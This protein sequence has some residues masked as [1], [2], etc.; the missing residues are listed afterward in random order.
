MKKILI[1]TDCDFDD[2]TAISL[3]LCQHVQKHVMIIGI[4]CDDGFLQFPDNISWIS[5][6]LSLNGINDIPIIKGFPSTS[7][8]LSERKF[9]S[10]W[11]LDYKKML[12]ENYNVDFSQIPP[13]EDLEPFIEKVK[14]E[15]FVVN[16]LSPLRSYGI[17]LRRYCHFRN[18]R[19]NFTGGG[20]ITDQ[21]P[22]VNSTW[23][24]FLDPDG[25]RDYLMFSNCASIVL[26]STFE[27]LEFNQE[28][29]KLYKEMGKKY[30]LN[31]YVS[32]DLKNIFRKTMTFL[33]NYLDYEVR[34]SGLVLWDVVTTMLLL[35]YPMDQRSRSFSIL[36]SWT[37]GTQIESQKCCGKEQVA[38]KTNSF[39]FL[40]S[41]KFNTQFV[42]RFFE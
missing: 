8:L 29:L 27:N 11:V 23:N 7:Y 16:L 40:D 13:Y 25:F 2:T 36:V 28:T 31:P 20:F 42:K 3:L 35:Q 5:K 19:S 15:T 30:V 38:N 41:E 10:N 37:G 4:V 26:N 9:P 39:T 12:V 6:W 32:E 34:D 1:F 14:L 24:G 17:L 33:Q 21:V 22:Q 18:K